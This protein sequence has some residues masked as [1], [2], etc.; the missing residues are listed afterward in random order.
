MCS[1]H[2]AENSS[3]S[4]VL[5]NRTENRWSS[6]RATVNCDTDECL[7]RDCIEAR[8]IASMLCLGE[9]SVERWRSLVTTIGMTK[10]RGRSGVSAKISIVKAYMELEVG[11]LDK[12]S[13][14]IGS[15][16]SDIESVLRAP[17]TTP[18]SIVW[19]S[20]TERG[21]ALRLLGVEVSVKWSK[22]AVG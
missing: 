17:K 1:E 3:H 4:T 7:V 18:G 8:K 12:L 11:G 9:G 2:F 13:S 19:R 15:L 21:W 22:R 16:C 14:L 20:P 5:I 10:A 6:D